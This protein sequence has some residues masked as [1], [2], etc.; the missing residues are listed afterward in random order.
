MVLPEGIV[1]NVGGLA[2]LHQFWVRVDFLCGED[3]WGDSERQ[4]S[5]MPIVLLYLAG[6]E[7][8]LSKV[9]VFLLLH[10]HK[11]AMSLFSSH[12]AFLV[13]IYL[14]LDFPTRGSD[15]RWTRIFL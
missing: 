6:S 4:I 15:L 10:C 12:S 13:I 1:Y 14:H 7:V 8:F 2:K 5:L 3:S 9:S 11:I